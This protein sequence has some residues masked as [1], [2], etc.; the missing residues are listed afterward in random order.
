VCAEHEFERQE[1]RIPN[2]RRSLTVFDLISTSLIVNV[3]PKPVTHCTAR[4][5]E[6]SIAPM[7]SIMHE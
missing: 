2:G 4:T 1:I 3:A 7:S 5:P 6:W